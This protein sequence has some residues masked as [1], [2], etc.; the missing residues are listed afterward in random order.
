MCNSMVRAIE[1][2][3]DLP[4]KVAA[5]PIG[6]E[7]K[8][9]V[10]RDGKEQ[11]LLVK[12]GTLNADNSDLAN[13]SE[14]GEGKWGMQ[15]HE[16]SPQLKEQFGIKAEQGVAVVG[17]DPES[18]AGEAGIRQ[19]DIIVEVDRKEVKS[20]D[21]VKKIISRAKDKERLLLLVQRQDGKFY[22]P[23]EQQG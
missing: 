3:N 20:I 9:T 17:V 12:V 1:T 6:E 8:V 7:V 10:L 14:P 18:A 19:G 13:T 2:S 21:D 11:E 5:T 4:V 16:L 22:I 23:L 15:L